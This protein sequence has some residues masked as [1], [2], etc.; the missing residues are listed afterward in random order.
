MIEPHLQY[1]N[2]AR[3]MNKTAIRA[4]HFKRQ[5]LE[6]RRQHAS[7][8]RLAFCSETAT[9]IESGSSWKR[10]GRQ[11]ELADD[12]LSNLNGRAGSTGWFDG[13]NDRAGS[14][15]WTTGIGFNG[16]NI[17][18][19]TLGWTAGLLRLRTLKLRRLANSGAAATSGERRGTIVHLA[20]A[21]AGTSRELLG[22]ETLVWNWPFRHA[23]CIVDVRLRTALS[24]LL[25]DLWPLHS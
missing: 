13:L 20:N 23:N 19:A 5:P 21:G 24:C 11:L 14:T 2:I 7:R 16:L 18:V 9:C 4:S 12:M 3:A 15:G 17:G 6:L 25:T 10:R 8:G 1:C 22:R